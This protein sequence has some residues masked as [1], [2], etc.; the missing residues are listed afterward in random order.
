M[1]HRA[2][3]PKLVTWMPESVPN[4]T[5]HP[6]RCGLVAEGRLC[7]PD[8]VLSEDLHEEILSVLYNINHKTRLECPDG[9]NHTFQAAVLVVRRVAS[10]AWVGSKEWTAERF[11]HQVSDSWSVGD[12]SCGNGIFLFLSVDDGMRYLKTA[13]NARHRIPDGTAASILDDMEQ[14]TKKGKVGE[15][16]L[17]ASEDIFQYL[18]DTHGGRLSPVERTIVYVFAVLVVF[19]SLPA[20]TLFVILPLLFVALQCL[21]FPLATCLDSVA[22]CCWRLRF[23]HVQENLER[24][25]KVDKDEHSFSI[26]M[27]CLADCSEGS[28]EVLPCGH[29]FHRECVGGMKH[30]PCPLCCPE[31]REIA[32]VPLLPEDCQL[33]TKHQRR[34]QYCLSRVHALYLG[35]EAMPNGLRLR[36]APWY[37]R[38]THGQLLVQLPPECTSALDAFF[39]S[40]ESYMSYYG[41]TGLRGFLSRCYRGSCAAV[42]GS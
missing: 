29:R 5:T 6:H 24:M 4:P 11:A 40:A 15:A 16:I 26:C 39:A 1:V 31:A 28:A 9:R 3:K 13:S 12:V 35:G 7:D 33:P 8:R 19:I 20:L 42:L 10:S 18:Y 36:E 41:L 32:D 25:Q 21:L 30:W 37:C 23:N 34:L 2:V 17:A 27:I 38:D 22:S 14:L